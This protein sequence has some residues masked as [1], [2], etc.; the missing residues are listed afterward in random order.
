MTQ[1]THPPLPPGD[2]AIWRNYYNPIG[3]SLAHP[4]EERRNPLRPKYATYRGTKAS[5][6]LTVQKTPRSDLFDLD[7]TMYLK[8]GSV[9]INKR[10]TGLELALLA[11]DPTRDS[12]G[13]PFNQEY[14]AQF[15]AQ[16]G[17]PC[18]FLRYGSQV[19][20]CNPGT[21]RLGEAVF[22]FEIKDFFTKEMMRMLRFGRVDRESASE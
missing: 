19:I 20:F 1:P 18:R 15:G 17:Y 8:D 21:G 22:C 5:G 2:L 12:N 13:R 3:G 10:L 14:L 6:F 7:A 16:C 11:N 9:Y 4:R